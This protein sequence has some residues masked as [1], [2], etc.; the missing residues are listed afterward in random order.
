MRREDGGRGEIRTPG[1][2]PRTPHFECG[3]F[4]RSATLPK[5][6]APTVAERGREIRANPNNLEQAAPE[7]FFGVGRS[8]AKRRALSAR[9]TA[10]GAYGRAPRPSRGAIRDMRGLSAATNPRR[11]IP[12]P[13]GVASWRAPGSLRR[14]TD[15]PASLLAARLP[16]SRART[17]RSRFQIIGI[18]SGQARPHL[19]LALAIRG[20]N[21]GPQSA[22]A[23]AP[24]RR[25]GVLTY[26]RSG[27]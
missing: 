16:D 4:N 13:Q 11:K 1:T 15:A 9:K 27:L 3:A 19:Q 8:R 20:R 14:S 10:G 2:V 26:K 25:Q 5:W 6:C 12:R 17:Q 22:A 23:W 21:P 7:G 18:G 24:F